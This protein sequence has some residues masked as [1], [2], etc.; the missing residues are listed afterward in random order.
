MY[1]EHLNSKNTKEG[2]LIDLEQFKKNNSDVSQFYD[3][4]YPKGVYLKN[5]IRMEGA[6]GAFVLFI[7][8]SA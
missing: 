6:C 4:Q 5:L 1:K 3:M 7:T 8:M 2:L